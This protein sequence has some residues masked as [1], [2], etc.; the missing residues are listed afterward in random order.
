MFLFKCKL[1]YIPVFVVL[2]GVPA[3]DLLISY[4]WEESIIL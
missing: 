1:F 3:V 4:K 2:E